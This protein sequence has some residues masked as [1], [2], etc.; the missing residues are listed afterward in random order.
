ML[1]IQFSE[2][3]CQ[4]CEVNGVWG[5]SERGETREEPIAMTQMDMMSLGS[6]SGDR[7]RQDILWK[8]N[9]KDLVMHCMSL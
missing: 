1:L 7:N 2:L 8:E 9:S 3:K 5:Q 6:S 4:C